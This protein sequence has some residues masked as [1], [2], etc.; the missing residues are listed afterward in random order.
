[1]LWCLILLKFLDRNMLWCILVDLQKL[2]TWFFFYIF[3]VSISLCFLLYLFEHEVKLC[4]LIH[5]GLEKLVIGL[6]FKF[7]NGACCSKSERIMAIE[8][9]EVFFLSTALKSILYC[10]RIAIPRIHSCTKSADLDLSTSL[11]T[12]GV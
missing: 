6:F 7:H 4:I 11:Y 5:T 9:S 8:E 12:S 2:Q 1:M 3:R 10:L